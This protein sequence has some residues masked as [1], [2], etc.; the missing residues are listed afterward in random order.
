MP[1]DL[2]DP[3]VGAF[4]QDI[5][6]DA[7]DKLDRG[8][9]GKQDDGVHKG[10]PRQYDRARPLPLYRPCG[11][12]EPLHRGVAVEAD[13]QPVATGARLAQELDMPRMEEI[14]AAVGEAYRQPVPAPRRNA[15]PD[16]VQALDLFA[17][18]EVR[19]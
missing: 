7:R 14:E 2:I 6:P 5:R 12:L 15:V 10:E 16:G 1:D 19:A 13:D 9:V 4:H 17:Q 18:F 3:V 8:I 11:A